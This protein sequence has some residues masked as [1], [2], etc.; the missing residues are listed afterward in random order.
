M[1]GV[2][3]MREGPLHAALKVWLAQPGPE[4]E[5]Q[6][7]VLSGQPGGEPRELRAPER[8]REQPRA[9]PGA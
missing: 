6:A 7:R 3:V 9:R 2:G 1:S 8:R 4:P 5:P